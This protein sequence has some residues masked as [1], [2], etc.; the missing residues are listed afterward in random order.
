MARLSSRPYRELRS[1]RASEPATFGGS[2]LRSELMRPEGC[3]V[4]ETE[5]DE[6]PSGDAMSSLQEG[7]SSPNATFVAHSK[8]IDLDQSCWHG[9]LKTEHI[10][11][12]AP[13]SSKREPIV[14]RLPKQPPP[15]NFVAGLSSGQTAPSKPAQ[16]VRPVP[17]RAGRSSEE[18]ERSHGAATTDRALCQASL[19]AASDRPTESDRPARAAASGLRSSARGADVTRRRSARSAKDAARARRS[20]SPLF[21]DSDRS[22]K[23]HRDDRPVSG[24]GADR[25]PRRARHREP[26]PSLPDT[27]RDPAPPALPPDGRDHTLCAPKDPPPVQ[28][29]QY[30]IRS[31]HNFKI[32]KSISEGAYGVVYKARDMQ[33]D[34]IVALKYVKIDPAKLPEV[35]FPISSIREIRALSQFSHPRIIRLR[36]VVAN[37]SGTKFYLV[38]DYVDYDLNQL[39]TRIRPK[40]SL[41]GIK[42]LVFQ[43]LEAVRYLHLSSVT[44]RDIKSSNILISQF[45]QLY[46][47]DFGPDQGVLHQGG[48]PLTPN[49]VTIGYRAPEL[50][51]GAKDYTPSIDIWSVGCIMAEMIL[52]R[53]L[54][55]V[56]TE[57]DQLT[58]MTEIF[59]TPNSQNYGKGV[60]GLRILQRLNLKPQ[61]HNNLRSIFPDLDA[62]GFDLL[63]RM[64]CYN[65]SQRI[66]SEEALNTTRDRCGSRFNPTPT[67]PNSPTSSAPLPAAASPRSFPPLPPSLRPSPPAPPSPRPSYDR[68]LHDHPT[69]TKHLKRLD[70]HKSDIHDRPTSS[71]HPSPNHR[72]PSLW[73]RSDRNDKTNP[74]TRTHQKA[75]KRTTAPPPLRPHR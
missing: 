48:V 64:L 34:E 47:A 45:G 74:D 13:H 72:N 52:G 70:P 11:H 24:S 67:R 29:N 6:G 49:V 75:F 26:L 63:S 73:H 25:S 56:K 23:R 28:F 32:I 68:H 22:R 43:L 12:S 61:P 51:F 17:V 55:D 41:A 38:L 15:L 62:Q 8:A 50:V 30:G 46:L 19:S 18:Q 39:L 21:S 9:T 1:E 44:H 35:G 40:F 42:S 3:G 66:T 59:G 27:A 69:S 57:I 2:V 36:E 54:I 60:S 16:G 53:P 14:L 71:S 4:L 33:T 20:V 5:K 37:T 58:R 65:P 10:Q 7:R 31:V